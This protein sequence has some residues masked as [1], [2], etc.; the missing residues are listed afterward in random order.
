MR[1]REGGEGEARQSGFKF[2]HKSKQILSFPELWAHETSSSKLC[3]CSH[4]WGHHMC[5]FSLPFSP[6]Y[7]LS[8][9]LCF[10]P[11]PVLPLFL[12]IA[13]SYCPSVSAR[14]LSLDHASLSKSAGSLPFCLFVRRLFSSLT[15]ASFLPSFT[16]LGNFNQ[17]WTVFRVIREAE[18][19]QC[20]GDCC[21]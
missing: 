20:K 15:A 6:L 3:C 11:H 2:R 16:L 9:H 18:E 19:E 12:S 21:I 4:T 13:C 5:T 14:Y 17:Q 7:F 10:P 8:S 1:G